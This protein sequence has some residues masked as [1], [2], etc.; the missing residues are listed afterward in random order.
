MTKTPDRIVVIGAGMGGL[1]AAA[2]LA[3]AG[4]EV[5]VVETQDYPGGKMRTVDTPAGPVDAGP[6][7]M[8]M[9]HVFDDLFDTCGDNLD[10]RVTL[11]R[12]SLL[13]RHFWPD[14]STLDLFDD[15]ERSAEALRNFAGP[16]AETD[17]RRFRIR[18]ARLF[19]A[20]EEP[21]MLSGEPRFGALTAHVLRDPALIPAMAPLS[22]L[23]S[24][25][26]RQFSDPRLRQLFGRYATYVG[27]SPFDSPAVL[28]LIWSAEERGVWRV[29]GGM[30]RLARAMA[31]LAEHRGARF[32]FGT[33]ATRVE[34]QAG[35]VT[36]VHL[37]GGERLACEGVVFNGDPNA[38]AEGLLGDGVREAVPGTAVDPRSLSARVWT[39]AATPSGPDLAHHNVFFG[40]DPRAEFGPIA[41]RR[42]PED[43][44]L[45]ICAQDRG[46]GLAPPDV[47]RFEI[48]ENAPPLPHAAPEETETC[49]TRTFQALARFGLR[50]SPAPADGALTTPAGFETLFPASRGSLYGRSPSGMMAAFRRPTARTAVPGLYLAGGGAHP[51]AGVPM[52]TLSGRHAAEA[53]LTDLASTSKSRRTATP[54]GMSTASA[55][56][57]AAPSRSSPS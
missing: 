14:G 33:Q 28:S 27:G 35:K 13:A 43:P 38:L 17:F 42:S 26:R 41:R 49:R 31:V 5:T 29:D 20:F 6:T 51:G 50:F 36:A 12:E 21:M 53:I 10:A 40:A 16:R 56:M 47:E 39:F 15:P 48:I 9:R 54:G 18:A 23:A 4:C 44:T 7:V 55:T 24:S 3:H 2:R 19:E 22:T 45:Y 46:T 25:L 8:T 37:Q 57:A 1:A 30:H 11:H 52:A 32:R 34:R